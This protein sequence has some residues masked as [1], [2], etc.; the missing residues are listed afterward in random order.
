[1]AS[2]ET[3]LKTYEKQ[4]STLLAQQGKFVV[5]RGEE[6]LGTFDTYGDALNAGYKEYGV[7]AQFFVQRIAPV[8]TVAFSTRAIRPCQA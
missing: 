7:D 2:F 1:M 4:L 3:E 6:V 8:P 5:I